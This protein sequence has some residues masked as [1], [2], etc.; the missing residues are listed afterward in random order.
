MGIG[1]PTA[2]T[3]TPL[4]IFE[5]PS[6][7]PVASARLDVLKGT[8]QE[9]QKR[10]MLPPFG[11]SFF[12]LWFAAETE[13]NLLLWRNGLSLAASEEFE[14]WV[15]VPRLIQKRRTLCHADE[16][17][18]GPNLLG[19][20][21][22]HRPVDSEIEYLAAFEELWNAM[23]IHCHCLSRVSSELEILS[24]EG[25]ERKK[26]LIPSSI[27]QKSVN[28]ALE[29]STLD[30]AADMNGDRAPTLQPYKKRVLPV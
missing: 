27:K 28:T 1:L 25:Q 12:P 16:H 19:N 13:R 23:T 20:I 17:S 10:Q 8:E 9:L 24:P 21:W 18:S 6:D 5:H 15:D 4:H 30:E 2:Q 14:V 11:S 7:I 29:H 3:C 26:I 22:G